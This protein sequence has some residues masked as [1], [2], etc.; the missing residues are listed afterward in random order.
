MCTHWPNSGAVARV[1]VGA[2]A[3]VAQVPGLAAI[4]RLERAHRRDADPHPVVVGWMGH[5][6][7]QAQ[8]AVARLP[9]RPRRV[10]AQACDVAPGLP[11]VIAAEQAG[12]LD[13]G[14]ERAVRGRQV[15]DRRDLGLTFVVAVG[16]AFAGLRP[17]GAVV[18]A[19]PNGRAVPGAAATGVQ[20][21]PVGRAH[22][23]VG[24]PVLAE[25]PAQ[26]PVLA[27]LVRLQ[28]EGTLLGAD[29]QF[30]SLAHAENLVQ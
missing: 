23:V 10:L 20:G 29:Q 6:R 24:R 11:A 28:D 13:A 27:R 1:E 15:P 3:L 30:D 7:V 9:L 12:R 25:G 16:Q 14:I 17:G 4:G 22:E 18:G 19:A 2:H 8:A 26:P 5:D 21:R